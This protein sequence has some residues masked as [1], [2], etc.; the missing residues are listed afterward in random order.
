[1]CEYGHL[2]HGCR[3]PEG[4][5]FYGSGD[6]GVSSLSASRSFSEIAAHMN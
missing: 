2:V 1:M 6:E 3:M 4:S 5:C